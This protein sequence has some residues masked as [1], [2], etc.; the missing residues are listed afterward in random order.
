MTGFSA[1]CRVRGPGPPSASHRRAST[2]PSTNLLPVSPAARSAA[3]RRPHDPRNLPTVMVLKPHDAVATGC[4]YDNSGAATIT[5]CSGSDC[6]TN[7]TL[8]YRW[9]P[10][11]LA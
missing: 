11:F 3:S 9:G 7:G 8:L 6:P 2:A 1:T 5:L 4:H 10:T